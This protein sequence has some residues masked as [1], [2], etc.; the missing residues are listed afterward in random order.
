MKVTI[1]EIAQ[2]AG[3]S[4]GTVDRVVNGR[5]G[6]KPKI[7][8]NILKIIR[9]S[10]YVPNIAAKALAYNKNPV[11]I[12]VVMPSKEVGFFEEIHKGINAA[13]REIH[14]MGIRV[15]IKYIEST[16][17]SVAAG[18]INELLEMGVSGM[19]ISAMDHPMLREKINEAAE[20]KIPVIT[21]NSD[22][23]GCRRLCFVGQDLY[24]SGAVAAGLMSRVIPRGSGVVVLT[25]S[26]V[27]QAHRDRVKGFTDTLD[28]I[29]GSVRVAAVVEGFDRYP[30]TYQGV[31]RAL[32]RYDNIN[33]IYMATGHVTACLE[34]LKEKGL[35]GKVHMICNDTP[36]EVVEN[37]KKGIID[38]TIV[39]DPFSQG[40]KPLRML[41]EYIFSGK[42]PEE[43]HVFTE[44]SIKIPE[45]L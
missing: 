15:E 35:S 39:Q 24:K 7:R 18:V 4:R 11:T 12:G 30:D 32:D 31:R 23:T 19:M 45:N 9:E 42:A 5:P 26:M 38:F 1:R 3:V 37:M 22:V 44:I 14:N 33:G 43:E 40:Y 34:A 10:E 36:P 21:F 13:V 2:M 25:G 6:V 17:P 20:R 29:N 16:E 28:K 27:F 8:E 41:H